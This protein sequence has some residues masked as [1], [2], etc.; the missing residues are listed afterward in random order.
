MQNGITRKRKT[1]VKEYLCL[2]DSGPIFAPS[3]DA[4]GRLA[5]GAGTRPWRISEDS[6][7][8]AAP[9]RK[10]HTVIY[11]TPPRGVVRPQACI[12][13]FSDLLLNSCIKKQEIFQ[14]WQRM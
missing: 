1:I 7:N 8:I 10:R 11:F 9:S 4:K 13:E 12:I 6:L 3:Q 5:G 2:N 14:A